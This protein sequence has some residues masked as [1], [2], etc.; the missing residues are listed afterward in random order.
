MHDGSAVLMKIIIALGS[1]LGCCAAFAVTAVWLLNPAQ[2]LNETQSVVMGEY[3]AAFCSKDDRHDKQFVIGTA[4][5]MSRIVVKANL[6][7]LA[8]AEYAKCKVGL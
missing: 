8:L 4:A 1:L 6:G 2:A 3:L 5:A 7:N